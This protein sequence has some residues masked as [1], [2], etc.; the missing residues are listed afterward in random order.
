MKKFLI[1]LLSATIVFSAAGCSNSSASG[2]KTDTDKKEADASQL[3]DFDIVLD[4]YPNAVHAFI[5]D[6]I[7]KGY[8]AEEGLNVKVQFPANTNDAISLT[9]AGKADA[10]LY[11][12]PDIIST[13]ANQNIPIKVLGT[14][15]QHPLN[16]VMSMKDSGIKSAKDLKGKVIG[17]PGTMLNET[18]VKAMMEHN[19]LSYDDVTMQDV[20]FDLNTALI[21]G[22]VDALIGTYINHE[23]PTLVQEGYDVTYFD[24][25]KE[26]VPDYEELVLI[27][28]EEQVKTESDKLERFIRASKKGFEDIKND[29]EGGLEILLKNQDN[30]NY[31][32]DENIEKASMDILIPLMSSDEQGFLDVNEQSWTNTINWLNEQG[33][34]DSQVSAEDL[35]AKLNS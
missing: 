9:A 14:V 22:N 13:V 5:Y 3:E 33:L 18:F 27:T 26:G 32:L 34:L 8:Y 17:Y 20:G 4:W 23:Y 25:T 24:I 2:T 12:Q 19:G 16:I 15:V 10:G 1:V 31:P 30:A 6:A 29:P 28:G 11:Y 21:T 7:E 35:M